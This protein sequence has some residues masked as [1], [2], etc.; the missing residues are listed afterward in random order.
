MVFAS[1]KRTHTWLARWLTA[2]L[3]LPC[4][5][6]AGSD[7]I[8][9]SGFEA[10][11][12]Q[13]YVDPG[14]TGSD[15]VLRTWEGGGGA[16]TS[17]LY[18]GGGSG[19]SETPVRYG[20]C[21]G[22]CTTA[23]GWQFTTLGSYGTAGLG[24]GARLALDPAGHPRVVWYSQA[25]VG[26]N[27]TL[28][29]GECNGASCTSPS[30]WTIRPILSFTS[31]DSMALLA[32]GA[33]ALDPQGRPR[34]LLQDLGSGTYYGQCDSAC[35][36]G[37]NWTFNQFLQI[38]AL[39]DLHFTA[40]GQAR[41]AYEAVSPNV[42]DGEDLYYAACNAN[43]GSEGNWQ[44]VPLLPVNDNLVT[45]PFSLALDAAGSP[46]IAFY[47][48]ASGS[49]QL[50]YAW[51]DAS[52]STGGQNTWYA[53]TTGLPDWSGH[54]GVALALDAGGVP[55]L[56]F[57]ESPDGVS[58]DDVDVADCIQGC[59]SQPLWQWRQVARAQDITLAPPDPCGTGLSQWQLGTTPDLVV[60]S[61]GTPL[62][63]DTYAEFECITGY[64]QNGNP[65]YTI[66]SYTGPV[67]Y[68]VP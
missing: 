27:G 21:S 42:I 52:C 61:R 33:F 8:F 48:A 36:Q 24:G 17:I 57:G 3:A 22:D 56:A 26:G 49:N 5:A 10:S 40:N 7:L 16:R 11:G 62:V 41:V 54:K 29:Y 43:C 9:R 68:A 64:D 18:A 1:T 15:P 66:D 14:T 67:A 13:P 38:S 60:D 55:H 39:A 47:Y 53:Y 35:T 46:R 28:F 44:S 37:S 65:I 30:A 58:D 51:C 59:T 23:S 12:P 32:R 50:A 6:H 25:S 20:E 4:L 45:E 63:Y 19:G 34:M 2:A 31:G